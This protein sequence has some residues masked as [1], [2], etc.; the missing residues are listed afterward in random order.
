M[1]RKVAPQS[2]S[3][4]HRG[5]TVPVPVPQPLQQSAFSSK[6]RSLLGYDD[7]DAEQLMKTTEDQLRA[8]QEAKIGQLLEG[9][10]SRLFSFKELTRARAI[11]GPKC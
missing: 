8:Q 7:P 9:G 11:Q 1:N 5:G 3:N 10:A 4:G 6:K 2:M